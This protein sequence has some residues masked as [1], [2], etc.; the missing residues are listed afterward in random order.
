MDLYEDPKLKYVCHLCAWQNAHD[1]SQITEEEGANIFISDLVTAKCPDIIKRYNI[2][3]VVNVSAQH[4]KTVA[5]FFIGHIIFDT[6][7]DVLERGFKKIYNFIDCHL[8]HHSNVL[9]HCQAGISRSVSYV[10]YYLM[11]KRTLSFDD[12]LGIIRAKRKIAS[13]NS[14]FCRQLRGLNFDFEKKLD[15]HER[16]VISLKKSAE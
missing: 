13:P 3:A 9:V 15:E 6:P 10:I 1:I 11:K 2:K 8:T 5:P 7:D 14:G 16:K 12:A 4:Y